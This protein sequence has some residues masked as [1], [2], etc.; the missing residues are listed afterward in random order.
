M[1]G[2][3]DFFMNA[4]AATSGATGTAM[5]HRQPTVVMLHDNQQDDQPWTAASE[6]MFYIVTQAEAGAATLEPAEAPAPPVGLGIER[7]EWLREEDVAVGAMEEDPR[8]RQGHRQYP[9]RTGCWPG[10]DRELTSL[11]VLR[12]HTNS[13]TGG[14]FH[15][16]RR[17]RTSPG[18][19]GPG[20]RRQ[21]QTGFRDE[22]L[23]GGPQLHIFVYMM[24]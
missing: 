15:P 12:R 1:S 19:N 2:F 11:F 8:A 23:A 5:P 3:G 16:H 21:Y 22:V 20:Q 9:G 10:W 13:S 24:E 7:T 17:L 14:S 18:N 6:M 4:V